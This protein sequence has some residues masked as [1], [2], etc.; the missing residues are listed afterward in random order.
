M[1]HRF[2]FYNELWKY[3]F[4]AVM[5]RETVKGKKDFYFQFH[6]VLLLLQFS[7]KELLE[8]SVYC[9]PSFV[10]HF[11]KRRQGSTFNAFSRSFEG[12]R[13]L[14]FGILERVIYS[15]TLWHCS[16]APESGVKM[17][18]NEVDAFLVRR[19]NEN[20]RLELFIRCESFTSLQSSTA[21]VNIKHKSVLKYSVSL[22]SWKYLQNSEN[23]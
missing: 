14:C 8:W 17:I 4:F 13:C 5:T 3:N 22:W 20:Y 23:N 9:F 18:N 7:E 12:R 10:E 2:I 19:I 21:W 1:E 16:R 11:E 15:W 6:S